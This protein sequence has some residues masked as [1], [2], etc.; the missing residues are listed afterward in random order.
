MDRY[1]ELVFGTIDI[2]SILVGFLYLCVGILLSIFV[3]ANKRD[4]LS[5]RTPFEFSYFFLIRDNWKKTLFTLFIGALSLR[6]CNDLFG[7]EP[8]MYM[9]FIVGYSADKFTDY[10]KKLQ[11]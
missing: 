7:A 11:R 8:T 5:T 2:P 4:L 9:A 1:I 10:I 6:F 3:D